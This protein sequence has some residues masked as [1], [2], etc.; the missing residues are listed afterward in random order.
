MQRARETGNGSK[1]MIAHNECGADKVLT[2]VSYPDPPVEIT[3][4]SV[5]R[6]LENGRTLV[7]AFSMQL[8]PRDGETRFSSASN[9]FGSGAEDVAKSEGYKS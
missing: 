3:A 4:K 1:G 6:F 2:Q 7:W 8:K 5:L 9:A